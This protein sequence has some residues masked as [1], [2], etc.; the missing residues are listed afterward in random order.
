[1]KLRA[2]L[3]VALAVLISAFVQAAVP[4]DIMD[5][6]TAG[7]G[8]G[9]LPLPEVPARLALTPSEGDDTAAIQAACD[10]VG[11]MSPDAQGFRGAVL[12]KSGVYR[13]AGQI[14][15]NA[16]GVVL[17][18]ANATL[19]ATGKS[20]RT[21]IEIRGKDDRVVGAGVQVS[22]ASVPAGARTLTVA[23][24]DGFSVGARVLLRRPSTK[25]WIDAVGANNFPGPGQYKD[26]RLEWVPGS[27]DIEWERTVVAIDPSAQQ[28]TL[29]APITTALEQ[30]F[31]GA[32]V[33]TFSWPGR[34][35]QVGVEGLLCST[36]VDA[37]NPLDEEHSWICLSVDLAEDVWVRQL[38]SRLFVSSCV[39]VANRARAVTV[40]DCD[41]AEPVSELGAWRRVSF[42]VGG[43]QVL[44]QRCSAED[45]GRDF[46]AGHCAAGPVVFLDCQALNANAPSGPFESWASGVLY[47][48]VSIQGAGLALANLGAVTQGAA[49][50]A[51]NCVLWNCSAASRI[52]I[53]NPP[54][55]P[56]RAVVD[57]ETPSLYHA[58]LKARCGEKIPAA[59]AVSPLPHDPAS[60]PVFTSP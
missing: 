13:I 59:L 16:S 54:G 33:H 48:R 21:L 18:G 2:F 34:L 30:K 37:T 55:A 3:L 32:T 6:S 51:A 20:R 38:K 35:R 52:E 4:S 5:F 50:T 9:A 28:L 60:V 17:R 47:D 39:W 23:S 12:L 1:M 15:L 25:A 53:D 56:N 43:Q 58:Q 8:G 31:G 40:I 44:V 24:I 14:R 22:D 42:Y 29:D 10:A 57:P 46:V 26:Q 19:I 11:Q 7:Y 36:E 27:R 49:W 41:S 45:G